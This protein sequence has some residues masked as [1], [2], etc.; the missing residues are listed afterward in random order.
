MSGVDKEFFEKYEMI[1]QVLHNIFD[2]SEI[3]SAKMFEAYDAATKY[4]ADT[5][6]HR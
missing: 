3:E 6:P 1:W 2:K 4:V 5:Y